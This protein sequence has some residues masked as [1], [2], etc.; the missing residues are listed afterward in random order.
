M[1]VAFT[2]RL[3]FSAVQS[4]LSGQRLRVYDA[5]RWWN[6]ATRGP[7]PSIEDIA[8]VTGLK[9]SSVCGRVNELTDPDRYS[10]ETPL[11]FG[12]I[13]QNDATGKRAKTYIAR[14]YKEPQK[15]NT[16]QLTLPF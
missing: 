13:K 3:S 5:V 14:V 1:P 8:A 7:G 4:Q 12:P 15:S 10:G 16:P 11:I 9:E 2:S 6:P